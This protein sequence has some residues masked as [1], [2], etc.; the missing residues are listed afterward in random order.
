MKGRSIGVALSWA[1][2][3]GPMHL[4][5]DRPFWRC[6][7]QTIKEIVHIWPVALPADLSGGSVINGRHWSFAAV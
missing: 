3:F 1:V 5:V 6:A 2:V 4:G 7:S